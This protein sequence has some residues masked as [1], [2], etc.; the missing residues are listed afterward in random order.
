MING[1]LATIYVGDMDRAVKFF[2]ETLGLK[3]QYQAGPEWAQVDAGK[4]LILGLHG[5]HE[6]GPRPGQNGSTT[7]GFELDEPI[8]DAYRKLTERGVKFHGPVQDTGHVKLAY[9]SD[10]DGNS[11]YLSQTP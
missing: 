7:V 5:T 1:G 8:E 4:G 2:T 3:L 10:P 9:F 6:G 11:F